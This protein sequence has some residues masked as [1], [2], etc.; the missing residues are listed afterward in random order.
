MKP[1]PSNDLSTHGHLVGLLPEERKRE[2]ERE[3]ES[4]RERERLGSSDDAD[5]QRMLESPGPFLRCQRCRE[6]RFRPWR[7]GRFRADTS[8]ARSRR[9]AGAVS[10]RGSAS[11]TAAWAPT[12]S[13]V[14]SGEVRMVGASADCQIAGAEIPRN[15]GSPR[16]F[17]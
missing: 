15:S 13:F 10:S 14:G 12:L 1:A 5:I 7:H 3:R 11:R 17:Q 4:E 2:R 9:R 8:F 6:D 16:R